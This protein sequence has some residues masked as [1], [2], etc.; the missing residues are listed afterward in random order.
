M[1]HVREPASACALAACWS[2]EKSQVGAL[3]SQ[4]NEGHEARHAGHEHPARPFTAAFEG[5]VI[6]GSRVAQ[7]TC[8][9]LSQ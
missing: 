7:V 8:T 6:R 1:S 3:E 5:M 9:N 2:V 4:R